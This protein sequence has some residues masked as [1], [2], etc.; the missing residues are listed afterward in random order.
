MKCADGFIVVLDL[1]D[2]ESLGAARYWLEKV[3]DEFGNEIPVVL[4]GHKCDYVDARMIEK[5]TAMALAEEM[6]AQYFETSVIGEDGKETL[7]EM[8]K[9]ITDRAFDFKYIKETVAAE[10]KLFKLGNETYAETLRKFD[11]RQK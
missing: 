8:M 10:H 11:E 2:K 9:N 3:R 7:D 4:A 1:T 5:K 6:N